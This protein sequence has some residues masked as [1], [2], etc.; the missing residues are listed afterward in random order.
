[1]VARS[2]L[3]SLF[4]EQVADPLQSIPLTVTDRA[5]ALKPR[6]DPIDKS[7]GIEPPY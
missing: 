4:F 3:V 1:M 2:H 7:A 6:I 5:F